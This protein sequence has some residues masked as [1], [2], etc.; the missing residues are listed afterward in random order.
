MRVDLDQVL[1]RPVKVGFEEEGPHPDFVEVVRQI[2]ITPLHIGCCFPIWRGATGENFTIYGNSGV[3]KSPTERIPACIVCKGLSSK[4][5]H[6]AFFR[7]IT[8]ISVGGLILRGY[9]SIRPTVT[10]THV[11]IKSCYKPWNK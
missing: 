1:Y 11:F 2:D 3:R 4:K 5:D 7:L 9:P 6:Y 8:V 10:Y